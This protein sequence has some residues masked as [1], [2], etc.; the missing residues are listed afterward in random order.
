MNFSAENMVRFFIIM[1]TVKPTVK[2]DK[3]LKLLKQTQNQDIIK[4]ITGVRR[5]GKSTLMGLF[6]DEL[7]NSGVKTNHI[8]YYNFDNLELKSS[9]YDI[10]KLHHK[11]TNN[12]KDKKLYLFLDEVQNVTKFDKFIASLFLNKNIDIYITGSNAYLLSSEFSTVLTGRT[13]EIKVLPF[14]FAEYCE[15]FEN[16]SDNKKLF[17]QFLEYG[18]MPGVIRQPKI[19]QKPYLENIYNDILNKDILVRNNWQKNNNF[20]RIS[21]F[22]FDSI[23]SEL[24]PTNIVNTLKQKKFSL[25][26]HSVDAY[27]NALIT[28]YLFYKVNRFD[29]KGKKILTVGSKY[30]TVDIGFVNALLKDKNIKNIGHKLENVVYLELLRRYNSVYVGKNSTKEV[31]FIALNNNEKVYYQVA[32]SV[33]DPNTLN[34]EL[35]SFSNIKDNFP[36]ILLTLDDIDFSNNGI[37]HFNIID[38]LLE[39]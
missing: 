7:K 19:L 6:I 14:S 10:E 16:T 26:H 20:E 31:D 2:R 9:E 33:I 39:K 4:V 21:E 23:G 17:A 36:K 37:K 35:S 15:F 5:S 8:Q 1:A 3:Y 34:R 11:I 38:W 28:S 12:A 25:S 18:A 13:F 30:Y 22:I 32:N 27:L 29:I 24:S